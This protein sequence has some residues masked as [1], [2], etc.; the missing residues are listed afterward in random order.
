M[1]LGLTFIDLQWCHG[2]D[3]VAVTGY[4]LYYSNGTLISDVGLENSYRVSGLTPDTQ[5]CFYYTAYDAEGNESL[6]SNV[7]CG[8]T[9]VYFN[10][11]TFAF[12]I[13]V[14]S[15]DTFTL[16][17]TYLNGNIIWGDGNITEVSGAYLAPSNT[18]VSGGTYTVYI[19][20]EMPIFATSTYP[21]RNQIV[22]I[23]QW[24]NIKAQSLQFQ[25]ATGISNVSATDIPIF[26]PNFN[27][28]YM[29]AG[30][31][32][33]TDIGDWDMTNVTETDSMFANNDYFNQ[34]ISGWNMSNVVNTS[35]MFY[36]MNNI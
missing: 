24:G 36:G 22:D 30:S 4:N 26:A 7:I 34:D 12:D 2:Q 33:N 11:K 31:T 8:R 13:T 25:N 27:A 35:Y 28:G 23:S 18:Y 10:E 5:Y 17:Q 1:A 16:Q 14:A 9:Q 32:F 20:G 15:G 3:N 29:F 19:N 21:M 6:T